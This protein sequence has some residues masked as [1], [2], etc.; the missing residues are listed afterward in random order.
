MS[1]WMLLGGQ[2]FVSSLLW[3]V[4]GFLLLGTFRLCAVSAAVSTAVSAVMVRVPVHRVEEAQ[5]S[6]S[7]LVGH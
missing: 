6:L 4:P 3:P 1:T 7:G 5:L 2:L